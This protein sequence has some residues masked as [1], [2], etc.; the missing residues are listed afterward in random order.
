MMT[1]W[2]TAGSAEQGSIILALLGVVMMT[3]VVSVGFA[4]VINGQKQTRHDQAYAQ[5][6]TGA[7]SGLDS[8]VA[9]VKATPTAAAFT[10]VSGTDST[11]GVSY[12][13]TASGSNGNWLV[14]SVGTA[15]NHGNTITR[16][17][18]ENVTLAGIYGVPLFGAT[19]LTAGSGSGVS[20]Y[21]SG[22][23][24]NAAATTCGV[25]PD[26][27]VLGSGLL[28]TTM[29]TPS[30][31]GTGPAATDGALTM[32][33]TDTGNFSQ[34]Y[35]DNAS[36]A[37]AADPEATGTCVGDATAC[38]SSTVVKSST[39]LNYP[40]SS[41]CASGIGVNASAIA[42]SNYLAAGAVYDVIGNLTLNAAVV[43]NLN[44]LASS[45]I[46]LCFNG[47]LTVPSLGAAGVTVPY[48]STVNSALPLTYAPRPPSTLVLIDT[49]T[50]PGTSTISLGDGLNPE[51]ALSAVIYAPNATCTATGHVDLYGVM[52][53]GSVSASSGIDVHYDTELKSS[54]SEQTVTVANWREVH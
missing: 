7:E 31:T 6:L 25:L 29:C 41:L 27:G 15:S 5:A 49:A 43:A 47:N 32:S 11:T 38:A 22:P 4:T 40:A 53:C 44:N 23:T 28:A 1:R 46:T 17:V 18:Q 54:T 8:M 39:A 50:T 13:A 26:T 45:G 37:G 52:V 21:D 24:G 20:E 16:E 35:I 19:A 14:D 30:I 51:T 36:F 12:Q 3:S 10:P 9:Q 33:G 34:V 48:N 42:G 2:K